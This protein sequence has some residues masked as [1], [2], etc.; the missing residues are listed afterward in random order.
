MVKA[1]ITVTCLW[2]SEETIYAPT[3]WRVNLLLQFV[4][5]AVRS[6]WAKHAVLGTVFD[7]VSLA[8]I[9]ITRLRVELSY[10]EIDFA[11]LF[12]F[13]D[14]LNQP[15]LGY[16]CSTNSTNGT[17]AHKLNRTLSELMYYL[18]TQNDA[19]LKTRGV[20]LHWEEWKFVGTVALWLWRA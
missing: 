4:P 19:T 8:S 13:K 14:L 17:K 11:Q 6:V 15:S 18:S 10:N 1:T 5:E 7:V 20:F 2:L 9:I 16:L 3:V 12:L